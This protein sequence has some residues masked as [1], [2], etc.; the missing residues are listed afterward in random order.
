MLELTNEATDNA[1]P[2][3]DPMNAA[4][5]GTNSSSGRGRS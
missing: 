3:A 5:L 1:E 4:T 2:Q